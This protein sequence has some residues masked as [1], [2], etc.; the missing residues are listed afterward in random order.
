MASK[1]TVKV[2]T[3]S[4]ECFY[5][6]LLVSQIFLGSDDWMDSIMVGV[7]STDIEIDPYLSTLKELEEYLD[8]MLVPRSQCIDIIAWWGVGDFYC[9]L[10]ALT[11]LLYS[12]IN[13]S[14]QFLLVWPVTTLLYRVPLQLRRGHFR[15]QESLMYQDE[16]V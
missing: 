15:V 1:A 6:E 2:P 7:E 12:S 4:G 9:V 13:T 11:D 5:D 3:T 16:P 14:I 8:G 10:A